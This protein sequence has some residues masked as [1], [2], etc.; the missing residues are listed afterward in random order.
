MPNYRK[1]LSKNPNVLQSN[2]LI[3]KNPGRC[4]KSIPMILDGKLRLPPLKT[5]P[6]LRPERS[7]KVCVKHR[8]HR[9]GGAGSIDEFRP[10]P[11]RTASSPST[12]SCSLTVMTHSTWSRK[13]GQVISPRLVNSPSATVLGFV[14]SMSEPAALE[15]AASSAPAGSA[16]KIRTAG[17]D[18]LGRDAH[19]GHEA[20]PAHR[21]DQGVQV[22]HLV[23]KL[24]GH[25]PLAGDHIGM[26][27][28]RNQ[29]RPGLG[30]NS[31]SHRFTRGQVWLTH[32]DVA[33]IILHRPAFHDRGILGHDDVGV[34]TAQLG[35]QGHAWAWLPELCVTTP[36]AA[37][38][39]L[40]SR[41]GVLSCSA[42]FRIARRLRFR[43]RSPRRGTDRPRP[44]G[45]P[46]AAGRSR[47]SPRRDRS[48]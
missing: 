27:V 31:L 42:Q 18:S 40:S 7:R 8:G 4:V 29:H 2:L 1:S 21:R 13:S 46:A 16:A 23:A 22:L 15:R 35:C 43:C 12:I 32:H 11:T 25:G 34:N 39:A 36:R 28:W 5:R 14:C 44:R 6:R 38:V 41:C 48:G 24:Q 10:L 45:L 47:A 30:L 17:I 3:M 26:V 33:A 37:S 9:N 20:A 19:A